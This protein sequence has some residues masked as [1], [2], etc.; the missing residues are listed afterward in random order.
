MQGSKQKDWADAL[1]R[2]V[3]RESAGKGSPKWLDVIANKVV[4]A[5]A[6]GDA[7]AFKEIGDRLDGRPKQTQEVSGPDGGSIPHSI[8]VSFGD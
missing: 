5:A 2:A 4:E 8:K 3:H 6:D 7:Q 1:R